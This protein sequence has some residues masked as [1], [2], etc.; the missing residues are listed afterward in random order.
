MADTSLEKDKIR[1]LLLEGIHE[2]AVEN[3]KA[4]GYSNVELLPTALT[5]DDLTA[6]IKDA[7][8]V[9]IRSRTQLTEEVFEAAEKLI[10]VGCFCIGTNQVD[11]KAALKRG[12]P[13][14]N[15]PYSN[16]RSVAELVIAHTINMMRGIPEK[17]AVAHRG[18]WLKSAKDSYEIR[19][20]TLGIVGYGNI[21]AQVSVLA[22][23]MGMRVK[24]YD[25]VPKLPLGNAEQVGT[26]TDLLA[27]SDVVSLHVPD[28]ADT[29]WMIQEE[30]IRAIKPKGYLINYARGKVVDIEALAAALNDGHLLGA[31]IDVFP[32]EPKG[33]DDEFISPLRE[34]D[35]VILTPHIGGSTKEAQVNIGTEVSEKLIRYSDNGAT[36]GAVNF[37]E[38]A[39]PPHPDMHRLL[40]T[41][42]NVPG[43][44]TQ[45][46]T[47]FSENGINICG[48]YLQT[49][50]EIGYVVIDVDKGYSQLALE[51]LRTID[52]TI[53]TRVLF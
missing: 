41:H 49:N 5:G 35:N 16:T 45:I 33:N 21:G 4:N 36:L 39:L 40:H 18:G 11:L 8:F 3:L 13:V 24:F 22:E 30:Q 51:K 34:F 37:P 20:K 2:N 53:R 42:K 46:N 26:L 52:G 38:V 28:T 14:F 1:V 31:A 7:H 6:K 50:E 12:I 17:N 9:G 44:L 48:Q 47:V 19:G 43:V 27:Q 25:V 15:A 10:G 32:E 23:S 29:R